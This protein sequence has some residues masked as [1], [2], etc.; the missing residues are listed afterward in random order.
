M[1]ERLNRGASAL[2]MGV[3]IFCVSEGFPGGARKACAAAG[4]ADIELRK[5]F[6][7]IRRTGSHAS[8]TVTRSG[9]GSALAAA[10]D[11]LE[12][13]PAQLGAVAAALGEQLQSS[14]TLHLPGIGGKGIV[15]RV[16][17][18][19]ILETT[20][21][22]HLI[23]DRDR[24]INPGVADGISR[25]W[26][27]FL[28]VQPPAG[29]SLREV[30]GSTLDAAGYDSVLRLAPLIFGRG[31]TI[32]VS[33]DFVVLR[34]DRDLLAGETRAISVVVPAD[35]LPAELRELAGEHRVRIVELTPDGAPAGVGRTPWRTP[36]GRVTTVAAARLAPIIEGIA[37][38]FG[39]SVERNL[40]LPAAAGEPGISAELRISREGDATF[41]FE[42]DDPRILEHL[43]SRGET[44]IVMKSSADL[45]QAIAALL[46]R[47]GVTAIGPTV[48][49]YR[50]PPAGSP[51]R[52]VISVP[53]WLAE[54]AGRR[55]LITG[56]TIP[57][58]VRL[59]L[60]RE[61]IDIFE[62]RIQDGR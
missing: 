34:S 13:A 16:A 21:G 32:R 49:F 33:P 5:S 28:V 2:L 30:I 45:Q 31:V 58:L 54:S 61:N 4:P 44:A 59:Y 62:Y 51:P 47:F 8:R 42:N 52:F 12:I 29:A 41:V 26:P 19:P 9:V 20:T 48:E 38:A 60:T 36:T 43:A 56:A 25:S 35:A 22:R 39:F 3:L 6:R 10:N 46:G 24:T 53:G 7:S 18:T 55:L 27:G 57:P 11:E 50:A 15:L 14:G 40:M 23:L 37:G 17:T 1:L